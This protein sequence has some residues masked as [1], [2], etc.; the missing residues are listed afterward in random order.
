MSIHHQNN[1][2]ALRVAL[3]I[4]KQPFKYDLKLAVTQIGLNVASIGVEGAAI[5]ALMLYTNSLDSNSTNSS[6]SL[7]GAE[8][9][10][11]LSI[12]ILS[13]LIM[14]L[15]GSCLGLASQLVLTNLASRLETRIS[16][17][18][19][20]LS[21]HFNAKEGGIGIS[22][23]NSRQHLKSIALKRARF[24]GRS[25][26]V[27][28]ESITDAARAVLFLCLCIYLAPHITLTLFTVTFVF[29]FFQVVLSRRIHR[30][31]LKGPLSSRCDL[32]TP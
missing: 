3:W 8:Y 19:L 22:R 11:S 4:L 32:S 13:I 12:L 17:D 18:V 10:I 9:T 24:T 6:I 2:N 15:I 26:R 21:G 28:M 27:M 31:Q 29:L 20:T 7:L 16:K 5:A 25:L 14:L 1:Q 30:N 23:A